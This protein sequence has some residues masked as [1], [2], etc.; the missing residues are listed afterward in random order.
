MSTL[1]EIKLKVISLLGEVQKLE[2][3]DGEPLEVIEGSKSDASLLT[4]G[5]CAALRR[6]T[7]RVWKQ[8]IFE[9]EEEEAVSVFELPIDLINVE[10]VFDKKLRVFIPKMPLQVSGTMNISAGNAWHTYPYGSLTFINAIDPTY[11]ATAYYAA[12]WEIP[13]EDDDEIEAPTYTHTAIVLYAT[14]YCLLGKAAASAGIAEFKQKIDS[15]DPLDIPA[16]DMAIFF[17]RLF[18]NE[19]S[20]LPATERAIR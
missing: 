2:D 18:E 14:S 8:S 15:G 11:G 20:G 16:K 7:A 4:E 12:Q 5:V 17:Q 19:L 10:A 3:E 9:L 13:V 6:I 1:G